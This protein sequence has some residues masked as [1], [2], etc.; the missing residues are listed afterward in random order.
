VVTAISIGFE[1]HGA[2]LLLRSQTG[3]YVIQPGLPTCSS[4]Q[5]CG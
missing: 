3:R 5:Q 1:G 2:D 4:M